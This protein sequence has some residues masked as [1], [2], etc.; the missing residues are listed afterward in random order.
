MDAWRVNLFRT[1]LHLRTDVIRMATAVI[2]SLSKLDHI[3]SGGT[4]LNLRFLPSLLKNDDDVAKLGNLIRS[5]FAQGGHHNQF[6]IVDTATL[7]AAREHPE[8]Y[9]DLLVR[10][11][12]T[13]II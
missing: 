13:A 9:R 5:Y 8:E 12:V 1:E 3:K 7:I 6:N 10:M 11:A 2:R 4:L